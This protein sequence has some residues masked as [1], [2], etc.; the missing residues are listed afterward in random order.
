MSDHG[1][2]ENQERLIDTGLPTEAKR[3]DQE[4]GDGGGRGRDPARR[5]EPRQE[6]GERAGLH[7]DP[8]LRLTNLAEIVE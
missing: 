4:I 7:H 3:A 5:L 1:R 2:D 8:D 6:N